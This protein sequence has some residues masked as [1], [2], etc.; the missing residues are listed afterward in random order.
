MG[1]KDKLNQMSPGEMKKVLQEVFDV[2]Y[3]EIHSN[4]I[5][6][7]PDKVWDEET[8]EMVAECYQRCGLAPEEAIVVSS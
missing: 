1:I 6:E 5:I 3:T 7:T 2:L 8:V 4:T